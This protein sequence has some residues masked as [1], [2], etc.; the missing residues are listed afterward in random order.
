MDFLDN[1]LLALP[2][3]SLA[4]LC[5]AGYRL[6]A[7]LV[8]ISKQSHLARFLVDQA[9]WMPSIRN[10]LLEKA[11]PLDVQFHKALVELGC[12]YRAS[13]GVFLE[14]IFYIS[15]GNHVSN[16]QQNASMSEARQQM[17]LWQQFERLEKDSAVA[18]SSDSAV[19][20]GM[21]PSEARVCREA[22][23]MFALVHGRLNATNWS[24]TI[25][26]ISTLHPE[27]ASPQL[28]GVEALL[29]LPGLRHAFARIQ[30]ELLHSSAIRAAR[31]LQQGL[32]LAAHVERH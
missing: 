6:L 13:P 18:L 26:P 20:P 32:Y 22:R 5:T 16:V 10:M 29:I 27:F 30:S 24:D 9:D 25:N 12:V 15:T 21:T 3:L 11:S 17:D 23:H 8:I 28:S 7:K 31:H 1:T 4:L 19:L 14:T 2:A